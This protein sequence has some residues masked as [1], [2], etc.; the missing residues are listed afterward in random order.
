M[1]FTYNS[2]YSQQ[3][4]YELLSDRSASTLK[5]LL[6]AIL[7]LSLWTINSM[8]YCIVLIFCMLVNSLFRIIKGKL[9]DLV[10]LYTQISIKIFF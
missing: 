10:Y 6:C 5:S 8:P 2:S 4:T 1:I 9:L 3:V 7:L